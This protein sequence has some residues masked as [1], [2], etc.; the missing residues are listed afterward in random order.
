M[1]KPAPLSLCGRDLPWVRTASHLG[2]ELHESGNME[3]DASVKKAIFISQSVDV[4]QTFHF[5]SP[6]EVISA[7]KVYCSSFYGC[8][9]WDLGGDGAAQI[10]NAW[11]TAVKL[12]WH[13]PRATRT[14]LVQKVLSSGITSAKVDILARYANF[15]RGLRKSPSPEVAVMAN[16]AGR[17]IRSTTGRNMKLLEEASGM[18]P[19]IFDSSRLKVELAIRETVEVPEQDRWRVKYLDK[20]M[21][22]KQENHYM[23]EVEQVK[24]LSD[25]IDSLCIN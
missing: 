19:W 25:L 13:V 23:G 5:A 10:Y 7:L 22:E 12:S 1:V 4:R 14:Y 6:V 18:D 9:L 8:M 17:D 20:L 3:H 11:S 16:I 21:K 2:H 24:K 15:F